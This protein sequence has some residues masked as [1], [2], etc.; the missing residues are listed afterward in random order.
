MLALCV[1]S[2]LKRGYIWD[3]SCGFALESRF[4]SFFLFFFLTLLTGGQGSILNPKQVFFVFSL[5]FCV[6]KLKSCFR[7]S[8]QL[9]AK[10]FSV[11]AGNVR[12]V[13][14]HRGASWQSRG[15]FVCV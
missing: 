1:E 2:G 14:K 12:L 4:R 6:A 3:M 5:F 15:K 10:P 11:N 8:Q 9:L 7:T 13:W